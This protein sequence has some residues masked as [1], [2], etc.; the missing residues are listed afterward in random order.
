MKVKF[1]IKLLPGQWLGIIVIF[2]RPQ[3]SGAFGGI[4]AVQEELG[5]Q[6][7]AC[8]GDSRAQVFGEADEASDISLSIPQ[9]IRKCLVLEMRSL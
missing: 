9:S 1:T 5:L 7:L 3:A 4:A 8:C 2:A 6:L